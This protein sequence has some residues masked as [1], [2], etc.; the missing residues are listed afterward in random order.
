MQSRFHEALCDELGQPR[1][2]HSFACGKC[3]AACVFASSWLLSFALV[4]HPLLDLKLPKSSLGLARAG[5]GDGYCHRS[6]SCPVRGV[7]PTYLMQAVGG[8]P[9]RWG[10][11]FNAPDR[12]TVR[13]P[14]YPPL[15]ITTVGQAHDWRIIHGLT[16]PLGPAN[17]G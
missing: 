11:I 10:I 8:D 6:Q 16:N 7:A 5:A 17:P 2:G 1:A 3:A 4:P 15:A 9:L 13:R 12:Q 14:Y